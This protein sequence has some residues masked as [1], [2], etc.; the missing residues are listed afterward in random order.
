M[1]TV[2]TQPIK[3]AISEEAFNEWK[4]G[5]MA[6]A[7]MALPEMMRAL[8]YGRSNLNRVNQITHQIF[9]ELQNVDQEIFKDS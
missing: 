7:K 1:T 3:D 6:K 5:I 4:A 8:N 9:S 2:T